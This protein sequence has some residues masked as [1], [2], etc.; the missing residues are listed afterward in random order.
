MEVFIFWIIIAGATA[1]IAS[2][3]GRNGFA[4]FAL[5]FLFSI[6]ALIVVCAMPAVDR[7]A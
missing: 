5:G 1:I 3:K 7:S 2:S 4:W 6:V